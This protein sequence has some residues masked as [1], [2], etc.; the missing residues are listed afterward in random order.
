[1]KILKPFQ[2]IFNFYSDGFKNMPKWG[3][4]A[5]VIIILKGIIIFIVIKFVFFPN[6]LKKNFDTDEQRSEH[7]L[8]QLTKTK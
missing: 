2:K 4:Q 5:W 3:K 7:V 6:Y 1:V 8:N